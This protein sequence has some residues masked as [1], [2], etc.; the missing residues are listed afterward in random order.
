MNK[1]YIEV[2][3]YGETKLKEVNADLIGWSDAGLYEFVRFVNSERKVV[4]YYPVDRSVIYK[5]EYNVNE[6]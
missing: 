4:A 1:Y 5:I 3:T 6:N 2:L